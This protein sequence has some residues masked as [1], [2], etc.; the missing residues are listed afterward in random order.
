MAYSG[1]PITDP[2]ENYSLGV[3]SAM[4][5]SRT[6]FEAML[7]RNIRSVYPE[8][9]VLTRSVLGPNPEKTDT[10]K[11]AFVSHCLTNEGM[12]RMQEAVLFIGEWPVFKYTLSYY[13]VDCAGPIDAGLKW[14]ANAGCGAKARTANSLWTT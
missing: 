3:P 11:I 9:E 10:S 2:E 12:V 7:R 13:V 5:L 4:F 8:V 1:V 6:L 14:L